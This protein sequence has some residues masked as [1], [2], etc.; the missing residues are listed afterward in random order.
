MAK[1]QPSLGRHAL[2]VIILLMVFY[3][4]AVYVYTR[5]VTRRSTEDIVLRHIDDGLDYCFHM[6]R[7]LELV[8]LGG[9]GRQRAPRDPM[10]RFRERL[11]DGAYHQ[12]VQQLVFSGHVASSLVVYAHVFDGENWLCGWGQDPPPPIVG[13]VSIRDRS[14]RAAVR[15]QI[16]SQTTAADGPGVCEISVPLEP[17]EGRGGTLVIGLATPN[18]RTQLSALSDRVTDRGLRLALI[19]TS[20]LALLG[21]YMVYLYR[22]TRDLELKL[23]EEKRLA[24]VGTIAAGMAHE[25]RNPLSSVKMNIQMIEHRLNEFGETESDY[26]ATKVARIHRETARLEESVNNFLAFA[27]P[28]PL[29][30]DWADMNQAIDHVVEFLEPACRGEGIRIV[31]D[32]AED[33]PEAHIDAEQLGQAVENL[34]RNAQQATGEGGTIEVYTG[35]HDHVVEVRVSDDG[36]GIPPEVQD[37][38]FEIFFTTKDAGSGLGLTIVKQIVEAHGGRVHFDTIEKRGTTFTIQLPISENT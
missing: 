22:R 4:L 15:Q 18:A 34:I 26:L 19:G 2:H 21:A 23:E 36:P 33:L 31:R 3:P 1:S 12:Q 37:K 38:V 11:S 6:K 9:D 27:R 25:I 32:Y 14:N 7:A 30:R 20:L 17:G 10:D 16:F 29:Q 24:Y 8:L 28:K 35:R 13:A 5:S